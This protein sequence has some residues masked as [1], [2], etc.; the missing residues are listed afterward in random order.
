MDSTTRRGI[1]MT[2]ERTRRRLVQRLREG[3]IQDERVLEV[4]GSTP[5]HLFVDEALASR[6]Y[7]DTALPI[8]HGQTISQPFVV[9]CMT[10]ALIR[11]GSPDRVLEVGTGSGYQAAVLAP[12]VGSVY[13]VERVRALADQ[14]RRR[15]SQ[16][17]YRNVHVR[18]CDG[19]EGWPEKAPFDA[20][21][22]TAAPSHL[23]DA[24]LEQLQ[25]GGRLVAPVG[26]PGEAQRL[27]VLEKRSD[28][29]VRQ[30]LTD[31]SFVPML[32]GTS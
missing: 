21:I 19:G 5:R 14:A 18:H 8:G 12:L 25:E 11:D 9:A 22:L 20:I 29:L 23:P 17:G 26:Q 32:G 13:T 27:E 30:I 2:S 16:L 24:L 1:G 31:V 7:D 15:L 4:I 28:G 3:G 10:E 6:A